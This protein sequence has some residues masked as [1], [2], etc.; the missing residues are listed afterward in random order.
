[1]RM[2]DLCSGSGRV[3]AVFKS[4]GW[5]TVT[6]DLRERANVHGTC[7]ALPFRAGAFDFIWASPP[8]ETFSLANPR[9]RPISIRLLTGTLEEIFRLHPRGFVLENVQGAARFI[10]RP[11]FRW[12]S[13]FLWSSH[14]LQLPARPQIKSVHKLRSPMMRAQIP[15]KLLRSVAKQARRAP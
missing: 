10:G 5:D 14:H 2:L 1:M 4:E 6:L 8:C 15:V 11:Q 13:R 3:A 7:L 9:A 12:G